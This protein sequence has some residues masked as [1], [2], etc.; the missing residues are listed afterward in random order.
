M[1]DTKGPRN[2]NLG[3]CGAGFIPMSFTLFFPPQ[4]KHSTWVLFLR[5]RRSKWPFWIWR[6][7]DNRLAAPKRP[8]TSCQTVANEQVRN[9]L[10]NVNDI[11][12]HPA[13]GFNRPL[14]IE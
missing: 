13:A 3:N 10:L 1:S 9:Q 6:G 2:N 7:F 5:L 8:A 14:A 11:G 4:P 12:I